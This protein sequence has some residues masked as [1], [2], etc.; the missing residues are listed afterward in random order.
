LEPAAAAAAVVAASK[1]LSVTCCGEAFPGLGVKG[2]EGLIL[3]G[4]LFLHFSYLSS[5]MLTATWCFQKTL[6]LAF[7]HRKIQP[8][9]GGV[10]GAY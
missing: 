9:C 2:V 5:Q 8:E 10:N 1:F 4:A 7:Q 3:V 6:V